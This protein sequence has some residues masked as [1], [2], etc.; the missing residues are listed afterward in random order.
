MIRMV[1]FV[2]MFLLIY[3]LMHAL[4]FWGCRPLIPRGGTCAILILMGFLTATPVLVRLLDRADMETLARPLA[5]GGYLWMGYLFLAFSLFVPLGLWH[6]TRE[7]AALFLPAAAALP[8]HGPKG[9]MAILLIAGALGSYGLLEAK[10]LRLERVRIETPSL[11]PG[12]ERL[13]IVQ[14]SDLHLGLLS[15]GGTARKVADAIAALEPDLLVATGDVVDAQINHIEGMADSLSALHPPWGKFAV[16]GNHEVYAGLDQSLQFLRKAGFT[17]LRNEK[18][19]VGEALT[20]AG[21]DDPAAGRPVDEATLLGEA[22]SG[23][24]TVL[25]K[26]R[27]QV[28]IAAAHRFHLQLSGH[29]HRGQIFPF[30]L[31]TAL[32]YPLQNG[33]Y[34]LTADS[35]LY[36]SRG[37]GT[38]GPP[39]R[40]F[41]PPE[42]TLF[43]IVRRPSRALP[44]V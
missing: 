24:F 1:L 28:D 22:E 44:G 42:I 19:P 38:W 39:M 26:H 29:A 40:V 6:L 32:F 11:P 9:A 35:L 25:L 43:E 13:R 10:R 41:S 15:R 34:P 8:P 2:A 7:G 3:A 37:T 23:R 5:L 20:V 36:T 4:V 16:T 21:V 30:T 14:I 33:L 17:V 12:V 27:P 18:R 31:L